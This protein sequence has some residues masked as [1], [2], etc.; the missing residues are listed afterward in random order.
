MIETARRYREIALS[1]LG[2][3]EQTE[4]AGPR[5]ESYA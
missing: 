4:I 1:L 2:Y 3:A 5:D